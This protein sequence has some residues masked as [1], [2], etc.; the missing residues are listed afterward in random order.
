MHN[1]NKFL[2]YKAS[3]SSGDVNKI[4]SLNDVK[5]AFYGKFNSKPI[6]RVK[7]HE[8]ILGTPINFSAIA[9]DIGGR[10]ISYAWDFGDN[11]IGNGAQ[12]THN[13]ASEGAYT[14]K[15]TVTD[16]DGANATA[17]INV[18]VNT[19][20]CL[21]EA[22]PRSGPSA[23]HFTPSDAVIQEKAAEALLEYAQSKGIKLQDI[24]TTLEYY[25]AANDYITK[26]TTYTAIGEEVALTGWDWV[27]AKK[28]FT[29]SGKR[30][31]GNKYCGD[32]EDFAVTTEAL[33]RAMG[34]SP[35]CAYVACSVTHCWN[36]LNVGSRFRIVEPQKN[37]IGSEFN[38]KSYEWKDAQGRNVYAA[39]QVINDEVGRPYS[40][41]AHPQTY[42]LNYPAKTGLPD[43]SKKCPVSYTTWAG[44]GDQTY[45]EDKCP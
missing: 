39:T 27:T 30:G 6:V 7:D 9:H 19:Y 16:N 38:S 24:D 28:L 43:S 17:N 40:S 26:H 20:N 34:V 32:C 25:E 23:G 13:Y 37:S 21:S 15:V 36:V 14:A 1:N 41:E 12:V 29:E 2:Q 5:I 8:V 4:V 22:A 44:Q 10:I 45:F 31:C 42:T 35:K 3:I 33:L 18:L 11:Q